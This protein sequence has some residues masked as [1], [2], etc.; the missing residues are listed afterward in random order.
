M[1]ILALETSTETASVALLDGDRLHERSVAGR[2]GHS[3]TILPE[4]RRLLDEAGVPLEAL[5]AIAFG[6]GPGAF[7]GLRLACGVAQGLAMGLGKPVIPVGT[8]AAL[9]SQ[10][11]HDAI[12]VAADARMSEVYFAAYRRVGTALQ[13][14]QAPACAAPAGV[15]LPAEGEWFGFGSAFR[16]Y[17]DALLPAL[18]PRLAGHDGAPVPLASSVAR[19][20]A[21][22]LAHGEVVD[23]ALA[24]PLYV[25][26]KVA[27]TTAERLA[28]GGKA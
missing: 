2:P 3:E 1:K 5:D 4:I 15:V 16:A 20:A 19:L 11:P 10:C 28:S 17:G 26:D 8:L 13:E 14:C 7:T 22:R 12:F 27:L 18:G 21:E 6:A 23:A 25:R 24:A 9:A